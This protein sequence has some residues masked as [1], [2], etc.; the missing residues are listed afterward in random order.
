MA[1]APNSVSKTKPKKYRAIIYTKTVIS[2]ELARD[3]YTA[4]NETLEQTEEAG[5][6]YGWAQSIVS[7]VRILQTDDEEKDYRNQFDELP[8]DYQ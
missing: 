3:F 8:E 7:E 4:I 5:Q 6:Q 1:K 2:E